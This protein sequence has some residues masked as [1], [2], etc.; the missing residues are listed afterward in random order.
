MGCLVGTGPHAQ[1][2]LRHSVTAGAVGER[3]SLT[4]FE[5]ID[6]LH[7]EGS[8][9]ARKLLPDSHPMR[10]VIDRAQADHQAR[11]AKRSKPAEDHAAPSTPTGTTMDFGVTGWSSPDSSAFSD[12]PAAGR[13]HQTST[14]SHQ[15]ST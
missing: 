14:S 1:K 7:K 12:A 11:R 10:S 8:M 5:E 13:G 9:L 2:L 15:R 6:V 4:P 3:A